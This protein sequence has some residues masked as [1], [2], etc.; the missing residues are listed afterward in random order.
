MEVNRPRSCAARQTQRGEILLITL[1]LLL[2]MLL[3]TVVGM[4]EGLTSTWMTG[5]TLARRKDVMSADIALRMVESQ[6]VAAS[7]GSALEIVAAGQPW[8]RDVPA[9]TAPPD[10]AYWAQCLNNGDATKRC[11]QVALNVNGA[12]IPYTA[13]AVVQ[14]T[15]RS[16]AVSCNLAQYRAAYYDVFIHVTEANG[17]TGATTETVYR[18]C[19]LN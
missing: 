10:D 8:W 6:M 7:G 9:G 1:V 16:D 13:L 3:A 19:T 12:A 5:N 2:L 18:I 17:A 15:G 14:P 11:A 4:R